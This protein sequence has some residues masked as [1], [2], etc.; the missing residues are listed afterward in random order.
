MSPRLRFAE[1]KIKASLIGMDVVSSQ[2]LQGSQDGG[3]GKKP[4]LSL[5]RE[6][7]DRRARRKGLCLEVIEPRLM[8]EAKLGVLPDDDAC[9]LSDL[10]VRE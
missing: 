1:H 7:R 4:V 5:P 6:S 9:G 3:S 8:A 10:H 2:A